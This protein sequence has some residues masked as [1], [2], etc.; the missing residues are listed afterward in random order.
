MN[1]LS[2]G[3][4]LVLA[5]VGFVI[6]NALFLPWVVSVWPDLGAM[7]RDPLALAFA[8]DATLAMLWIAAYFARNAPGPVRWP[9]FIVLALLGGLAF[10]I[11]FF[12]W[13]NRAFSPTRRGRAA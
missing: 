9:W 3:T 13:C 1:R 2:N 12:V 10:A 6:P 11:P 4:L 5:V 8:L 7:L